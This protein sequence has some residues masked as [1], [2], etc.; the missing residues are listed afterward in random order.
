[1]TRFLAHLATQSTLLAL[2]IPCWAQPTGKAPAWA[3]GLRGFGVVE[4]SPS[5]GKRDLESVR[6]RPEM[7]VAQDSR[8]AIYVLDPSAGTVASYTPDGDARDTWSIRGW[9]PVEG[10][11][12]LGGFAVDPQAHLMAY[13]YRGWLRVFD[14]EKLLDAF[15][16]P[17][18]VTGLALVKG[19]LF[20]AR[21]PLTFHRA[22]GRQDPF[23]RSPV[24]LTWMNLK[25]EVSGEGLAPDKAEAPDAFSLAMTQD[26]A[27]AGDDEHDAIWVADRHRL[28]R[29]RRLTTS[30]KLKGEWISPAVRANVEFTG[31]VPDEAKKYVTHEAVASF[32]PVTAR[33]VARAVVV[34]NGFVYV[35]LSPGA[36]TED[37]F[38]DVFQG[39]GEGPLWRIALHSQAGD[40]FDK[41]AVTEYGFWLFP[42]GGGQS[43]RWIERA[44]DVV[45]MQSASAP[46]R[47]NAPN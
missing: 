37:A 28:Y 13:A 10:S 12:G 20:A 3:T 24:L 43:P 32:R 26:I 40:V 11:Q 5:A 27:I 41:F 45:M 22:E 16:L 44:P 39:A 23:S 14:R 15:T 42:A 29:L 21:L 7:M 30:G 25:G 33:L 6:W 17:T 1:M 46:E 47:T 18:F 4:V 38:I 19:E 2:A 31:T 34:R 35:L 36:I 9:E 8:D